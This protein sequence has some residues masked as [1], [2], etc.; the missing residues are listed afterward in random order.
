MHFRWPSVHCVYHTQSAWC[1]S[2]KYKLWMLPHLWK[3]RWPPWLE[4]TVNYAW[5]S[6][7]ITFIPILSPS[8]SVLILLLLEI[9]EIFKLSNYCY[10]AFSESLARCYKSGSAW[11]DEASKI[12]EGIKGNDKRAHNSTR[13][14]QI[15]PHQQPQIKWGQCTRDKTCCFIPHIQ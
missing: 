5:K 4:I 7:G 15:L 2:W 1:H 11:Q 3:N 9:A 10:I 14:P 8:V 13:I 12:N 6:C